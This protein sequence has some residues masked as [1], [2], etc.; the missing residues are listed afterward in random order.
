MVKNLCLGLWIVAFAHPSIAE[1]VIDKTEVS[2]EE[3][4]AFQVANPDYK[5]PKY[6][7]EYRSEF[8]IN[9][10]AAKLAPFNKDTFTKPNHPVVGV[11]WSVA[12]AYCEWKGKRLPSRQEWMQFAG[13]KE[14]RIWPWGNEWDYSKANTG[15]E[16]WGENDG[17]IYSAPV[18]S[19]KEG[20]SPSG[21][22]NMAGNVAEWTADQFVVGGSSNSS[23]SG[24]RIKSHIKREPEY[25]SFDIGFRCILDKSNNDQ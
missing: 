24:V 9:S 6:W 20:I 8:F 12:K 11:D 17:Y 1:T 21:A 4:K 25:R 14:N 16:K 15:G 18:D 7:Q 10:V 5:Q 13:A 23:P 22:L 19:F 2:N 3:Y